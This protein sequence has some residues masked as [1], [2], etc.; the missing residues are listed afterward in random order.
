[1]DHVEQENPMAAKATAVV[2]RVVAT[3]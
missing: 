1:V 2:A 3:G